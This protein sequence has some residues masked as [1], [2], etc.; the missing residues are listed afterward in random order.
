MEYFTQDLN[1]P[2]VLNCKSFAL[3]AY[4]SCRWPSII[5]VY[6]RRKPCHTN[7]LNTLYWIPT[8]SFTRSREHDSLHEGSTKVN[9]TPSRASFYIY[10]F[11]SYFI[12]V[13]ISIHN[14]GSILM[15]P[16]DTRLRTRQYSRTWQSGT[17]FNMQECNPAVHTVCIMYAYE[18][19]R[20]SFIFYLICFVSQHGEK[21]DT[22]I[23][24]HWTSLN[25]WHEERR[26]ELGWKSTPNKLWLGAC[27]HFVA[28]P[29]RGFGE[30]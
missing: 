6:C 27:S 21:N 24:N 7:V 20:G 4:D 30:T 17:C 9:R 25:L 26:K 12:N 3:T 10:L 1:E 28:T 18:Y 29:T 14:R 2:D 13:L 23:G 19:Q 5:Q 11:S 22:C 8:L 16:S 15:F